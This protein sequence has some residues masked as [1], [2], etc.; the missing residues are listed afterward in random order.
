MVV[1]GRLFIFPS[2]T[3]K[4]CLKYD[5][6]CEFE[7]RHILAGADLTEADFLISLDKKHILKPEVEKA[8]SPMVVCSPKEFL[9]KYLAR[10]L[11]GKVTT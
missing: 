11:G 9:E 10:I 8:L 6:F 4:E 5:K 2:P 1:G 7:D 3:Q